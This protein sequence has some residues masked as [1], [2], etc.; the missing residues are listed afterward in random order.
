VKRQLV[1]GLDFGTL[2]ARAVLVSVQDG[3]VVSES[4]FMYPHG[5]I[6][7]RLES[8]R[9]LPEE[10]ALADARD[11]RQALEHC[12][13]QA[14]RGQD[15]ARLIGIGI[16]A[17]TYTM[18]PCAENGAVLS[19]RKAFRDEPMAYIKLW[20]HHGAKRQADQIMACH[21]DRGMFAVTERYG[22]AVNCE[23]AL[24]KL[25]ETWETAPGVFEAAARFCD[26]GE[27]IAWL[28][29]GRPVNSI[30]SLGFKGMWAPD[31]GFPSREELDALGQGFA[32]A[33]GRKFA[34]TPAGFERACGC[35]SREAAKWLGLPAGIPVAT[36]LGD[37]SCP[38]V[39]YCSRYPDAIAITF[40]TSVAMAFVSDRLRPVKGINGVVRDG[41]LPGCYGYDA[42]QPCAGDMLDWFVQRQLPREYGEQA[43]RAGVSAHAYLSRLAAEGQPWE[44][45]I[46]VLDWFNGNRS[47]LNN[48]A[49]RGVVAGCSLQTRPEEIYCGMIQG[50][51][52]GT[53]KILEYLAENGLPFE[54][55]ILCGGIAEKNPFVLEQI[56][57]LL[58]REILHSTQRQVTAKSAAILGAA[59]SG[60][61]LETAARAMAAEKLT[62]VQP[63]AE[64]RKEYERIYSSWER[65]HNLLAD[66][67][68][69]EAT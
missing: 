43:D 52:C 44:N 42:G 39:Y 8:G 61:P 26:L 4:E 5:V 65:L 56:A 66:Y 38:G 45:R 54:K 30:Y 10:Y 21:R 69:E 58:G 20:K 7:D 59:A 41:I 22:G 33:Y 27:W 3:S 17:T 29:T 12:V 18:V 16:S 14:V 35:L 62:P 51:A 9:S 31:L 2:S 46:R 13:S 37:G 23:W 11:Y 68:L 36:P 49:L 53:R 32:E 47:I 48:Q 50:L 15:T 25:L 55:V 67:Y 24:P 6:S 60:I 57:S 19:E 28:L 40:G 63:D 34:G 1:L 64:H